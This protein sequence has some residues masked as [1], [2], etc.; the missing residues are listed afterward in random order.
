MLKKSSV[1]I[2]A[3]SLLWSVGSL[4]KVDTR[5]KWGG[6]YRLRNYI[7]DNL[8]FGSNQKQDLYNHRLLLTGEMAP[9]DVI[10]AHFSFNVHQV[11][12][13]QG[14][15]GSLGLENSGGD[16]E[17]IQILTAYA[18]WSLGSSFFLNLGR[19]D[20]SWGNGALVSK[21]MDDQTP[22]SFDGAVL[23]Y[24]SE[25]FLF[26]AG[27]LRLGDW[28]R[29]LG[30]ASTIDPDESSY[31]ARLSFKSFGKA[32]KTAEFFFL[33]L[34]SADYIDA[35]N[36]I[37]LKGFSL[38]RL[39]FSFAGATNKFFYQMD[40][41]NLLGSYNGGDGAKAWLGHLKLGA[42]FGKR[43]PWAVYMIGHI[44]SGDKASSSA[45]DEGYRPIYYNHHKYAGQMDLLAWGNLTY[46]GLGATLFHK[47]RTEFMGQVLRFSL[48]NNFKGPSSISYLGYGDTNSFISEDVS[49][50][51]ANEQSK[52]L[53]TEFDFV[54]KR[55]FRSDAY[56]ELILGAF[57]PDAYFEAYGR[58]KNVYSLRLSTGF[59]F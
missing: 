8:S 27:V 17:Q 26:S 44:D 47:N 54:M 57:L 15:R 14:R 55:N 35:A 34:Q 31:F 4:A 40:Y 20:L 5:V 23:G 32:L 50:N 12:G 33:R 51:T 45:T 1:L 56:I 24:D 49:K 10:E 22:Y 46:Y 2:G 36:S 7:A 28:D 53:G 38:N 21:N 42:K 30:S 25:S 43:A 9:N 39:G 16:A 3:L 37:N 18:D 6:E 41:V 58:L 59:S 48:T 11:I 52:N 13:G 19:M 29:S